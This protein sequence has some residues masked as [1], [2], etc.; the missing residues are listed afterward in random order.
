MIQSIR[1]LSEVGAFQRT[2]A[3]GQLPMSKL[4]FIYAENGRGKTTLAAIL[5]SLGNN[6]PLPIM[7]RK[8]LGSTNPPHIVIND[9]T[10]NSAVF[11]NGAWTNPFSD[12][13]VFDDQFVSENVCSG[14]VVEPSHR[15]NLHEL[16]IGAQGVQLN[17]E[18][19]V[20]IERVEKH[21]RDQQANS[22]AISADMR[23]PY[24][25]ETF[26]ALEQ[27]PGIDDAIQES[28]RNLAAA[29]DADAVLK[30]GKFVP[31]SL[32]TFDLDSVAKLL[33]SDLPNLEENAAARVQDHVAKLGDRGESWV[34]SGMERV[35]RLNADADTDNDLCPFCAQELSESALIGHYQAYFSDAYQALND[36]IRETIHKLKDEHFGDIPA[37]FER[38]VAILAQAGKFWSQY[39]DIPHYEINTVEVALAWKEAFN[40]VLT[41]LQAKQKNPLQKHAVDDQVIEKVEAFNKKRAAITTEF[42]ALVDKNAQIDLVKEKAAAADVSIL[43]NDLVK[44]SALKKRYETDTAALCD[45]Y[46]AEKTAKEETEAKRDAARS[47]LNAYRQNVFP[48]YENSINSYLEH[49][50]ASF[51]L[52]SVTS[53]N[54][55]SGSSC[56]YSVLINDVSVPISTQ[57]DGEPTFRNTLSAG[58]RNAL[59]LAF[60]FASLDVDPNKS[61]KT[62]VIDDPM[63]SLDEHRTLATIQQM[64]LLCRSVSQLIVLSHSKTFLCNLWTDSLSDSVEQS[65]IKIVRANAGS[66]L[67]SWDV[68]QDCITEHDK[69]HKLVSSYI[70][71]SVDVNDRAV[72]EALR[73]ILESFMRVAYPTHFRPGDL[74]GRFI[75]RCLNVEG[76]TEEIL[77]EADR[78]ELRALLD[79]AN[80]FHHDSNTAW[81]TA[82]INDTELLDFARRTLAFTRR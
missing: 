15:Q 52:Q 79:Y 67:A 7:E 70:R 49:F 36:S 4:A 24:N 23:G 20:H 48:R 73:P 22:V 74:L 37:A 58:D 39:V 8:R 78:V 61:Q 55:R 9:N 27:R 3:G 41:A 10:T 33:D 65:A 2:D 6:D 11:E 18:L 66:T 62:V 77:S 34:S 60:F 80:N 35:A 57:N 56:S 76:S 44:L 28:E 30:Q 46:N 14:M 32:P 68:N 31:P 59:A 26:C 64:R 45:A 43:E 21:N 71:S 38:D 16:I 54:N 25:V 1:L 82:L 19:Q 81:R 13:A 53:V 12:I 69:R 40:A 17:N 75:G 29:R 50:N 5:R 63:T 47:A 72:A 51:R 42:D